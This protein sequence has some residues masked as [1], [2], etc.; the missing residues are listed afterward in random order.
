M[1]G[2]GLITGC[3]VLVTSRWA[4]KWGACTRRFQVYRNF[5]KCQQK[6]QTTIP[7]SIEG[8]FDFTVL[9]ITCYKWHKKPWTYV[10]K[11]Q[12]KATKVGSSTA[13]SETVYGSFPILPTGIVA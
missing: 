8:G 9:Q 3:I 10:C 4:F 7:K 2:G 11:C 6:G 5:E 13:V 12:R 1:G